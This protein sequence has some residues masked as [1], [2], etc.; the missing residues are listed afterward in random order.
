MQIRV[1]LMGGLKAQA[2]ENNSIDLPDGS[3]IDDLLAALEV[4]P[5]FVQTVMLNNKPQKDRTR[6]ISADD[7]LTLLPPVGGG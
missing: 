6:V 3:T 5:A 1:N 7:E 4:D 2:P